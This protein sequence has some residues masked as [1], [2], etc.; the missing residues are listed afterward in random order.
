MRSR[1]I[2]MRLGAEAPL[3]LVAMAAKAETRGYVI[4]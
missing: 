4:S 3:C 1:L 2:F